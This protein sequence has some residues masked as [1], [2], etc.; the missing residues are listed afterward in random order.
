VDKRAA[1][2]ALAL[3]FTSLLFPGARGNPP[4]TA[5]DSA[6]V[7]S[8]RTSE[9]GGESLLP[10]GLYAEARLGVVDG[11]PEDLCAFALETLAVGLVEHPG[12]YELRTLVMT[13]S[14]IQGSACLGTS[15]EQNDFFAEQFPGT[16]SCPQSCRV[17]GV[18]WPPECRGGLEGSLLVPKG[19]CGIVRTSSDFG[20]MNAGTALRLDFW[21]C[22]GLDGD[23]AL[24]PAAWND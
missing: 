6:T 15:K 24:V 3:A 18:G 19:E 10:C 12:L 20:Y 4:V 5:A 13:G 7:H 8:C 2:V 23:V 22:R 11:C 21:V 9:V 1:A 16:F 17:N 14:G